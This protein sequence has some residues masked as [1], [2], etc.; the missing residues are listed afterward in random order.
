MKVNNM[1]ALFNECKELEYL[2]LSNFNTNQVTNMMLMFNKC[3]KL[4]EIK[5]IN[6]FNTINVINMKGMFQECFELDY[7]DLSNFNTVNVTDMEF[8]FFK[9]Y[10][11]KEIKGINKFNIAK[12]I[13]KNGIFD[14]CFKLKNLE[15]ILS[16]FK[17]SNNM[18]LQPVNWV[19][20]DITVNFISSD[21][22]IN[23][24]ITCSNLD[25]FSKLVDKLCD[26]FPVL[27]DKE[28]F[29]LAKGNIMIPSFNLEQNK[30]A[31]GEHILINYLD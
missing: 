31:D 9:C 16:L 21:Q 28:L 11:L 1:A 22:I 13:L 29:F 8:M 4:K 10:K 25:L 20:K 7:L 23:F 30:L 27:K 6:N 5:G 18:N 14:D 26:K 15:Q 17:E 12:I 3:H 2:N 24:S 19:K